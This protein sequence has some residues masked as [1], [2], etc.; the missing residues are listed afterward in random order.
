[1]RF[2][3]QVSGQEGVSWD[4]WRRVVELAENLGFTTVYRSDHFFSYFSDTTQDSLDPWM[5]LT[6]AAHDT[7]KIRL[8]TLVTPVTFRHPSLLARM[9]A[10]VD[11]LSNGR[12]ELGIGGGHG[13]K[14]HAAFDIP[15]P[16]VGVRL[17]MLEEEAQVLQ[18][19]WGPGPATFE[20]KHFQL[21]QA[22]CYPKPVQSPMPLLIGGRA[23]RTMRI[24]AKYAS[25][26]NTVGLKPGEYASKV[27]VLEEHCRR[28]GR[29]PKSLHRSVLKGYLIGRSRAEM[30]H[31]LEGVVKR[32]PLVPR[33]LEEGVSWLTEHMGWLIGTPDEIVQQVG[34]ME[35]AGAQEIM[36]QHL[37]IEDDAKLELLASQVLSKF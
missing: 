32:M 3:M 22:E 28:L 10:Q 37:A 1:M 18:K 11:V 27:Q 14:E 23:D 21:K 9:A 2:G 19:L 33:D 15:F 31:H 20:G 4:A 16:R 8:G 25:H 13:E 5:A 34:G 26:W 29:D 30:R 17:D 24:A 36:F 12:V 35:D 7:T 6:V